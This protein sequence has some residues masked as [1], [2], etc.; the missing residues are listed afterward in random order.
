PE[1]SCKR[2]RGLE[3]TV[4]DN[5]YDIVRPLGGGGMG[6]VYLA[7]DQILDRDVA[8]KVLRR[9]YAGDDEFAERFKREAL[10]AASLSHPNIVQVYDRGQTTDGAAYIAMEYVPGGTLK[11]RIT[12]EG[13]LESAVAASIGSQVAEALETAHAK[14]VVHRDIKPQNVLLTDKGDAKV[15]DFGIARATAAVT[16]SQTGSVMGTASYMSPEQALGKP[17]TPK[18]D[19]YSLGIVLYEA[20]TGELPYTADN[21]IAVSMKHVND[22]LR[23]PREVNPQIPAGMNALIVKL[24]AKDP[25]DR[26]AD[27]NEL[28]DDLYRVRRGVTPTAAGLAASEADPTRANQPRT[29]TQATT[30]EAAAP[31]ARPRERRKLPVPVLLLALLALIGLGWILSQPFQDFS[32][33]ALLGGSARG[34]EV[35]SVEGLTR[36]EAVQRL[37]AAGL[38]AEIRQR[39][40]SAADAGIV[41]EQSPSG[42]QSANRGSKVLLAVGAGAST[43]EVPEVR[44]LSLSEAEAELSQAGLS[45]GSVNEIT[46]ETAPEG[47]VIEQGIGP[48]AAV[49]PGTAVNLGISSGPTP[50]SSASSSASA[51]ASTA[52]SSSASAPAQNSSSAPAENPSSAPPNQDAQEKIREKV[53]KEIEKVAKKATEGKGPGD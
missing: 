32:F 46:S 40:N 43:V 18:S 4:V 27:A 8:L 49:D 23:P 11:E 31:A 20:I 1:A 47:E 5:R 22:P 9:Q 2:M 28:A 51:S 50:V 52:A 15:A 7:R 24:L 12:K 53:E 14:G 30:V 42:G 3:R 13:P 37:D 36:D 33:G 35:P 44:G 38:G 39:Q 29:S 25:E 19:L 26:Y 10:N 17:A 21:P 41:L 6:E 48:G 45:V 16:I 34:V